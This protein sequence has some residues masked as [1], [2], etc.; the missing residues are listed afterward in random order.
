MSRL[1]KLDL[2]A[3]EG[4]WMSIGGQWGVR[5]GFSPFQGSRGKTGS[6]LHLSFGEVAE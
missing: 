1:L 2:V 5:V 6:V 4:P 3:P